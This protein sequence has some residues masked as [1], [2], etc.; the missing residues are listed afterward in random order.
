MDLNGPEMELP[1]PPRGCADERLSTE[2]NSNLPA[3][4]AK[5]AREISDE[6]DSS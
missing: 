5:S 4:M 1:G 3:E 2:P 6:F